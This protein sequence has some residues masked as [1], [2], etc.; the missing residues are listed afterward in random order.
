[1]LSRYVRDLVT[2]FAE[3]SSSAISSYRNKVLYNSVA[4]CFLALELRSHSEGFRDNFRFR[5]D[6]KGLRSSLVFIYWCFVRPKGKKRERSYLLLL[7][8]IQAVLMMEKFY[9]FLQNHPGGII[10][11]G[12]MLR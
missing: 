12:S 8:D 1:M 10:D 11:S 7:K 6:P 2:F 3:I 5:F 9:F 4:E